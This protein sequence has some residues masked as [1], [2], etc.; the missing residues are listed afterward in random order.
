MNK[1]NLEIRYGS[2]YLV[3]LN[4]RLGTEPGKI[5]PVLVVQ[6]N[7]LNEIKH[8]STLILP[9]TTHLHGGN[10]LRVNVPKGSAGNEKECEVMIDQCRAIDNSRFR[11]EL[12]PLPDLILK[13]VQEKLMAIFQP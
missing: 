6:N 7:L 12:N 3:D 1:K 8:P 4:P 5:R 10:K 9:C 2:L 13:E 11:K